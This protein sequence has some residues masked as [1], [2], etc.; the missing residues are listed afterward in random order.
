MITAEPKQR[1]YD[2]KCNTW[3]GI[4]RMR[5]TDAKKRARLKKL[6]FDIDP[7]YVIK[8]FIETNYLCPYLGVKFEK[9]N[10][11]F[12]LSIDRIDSKQGY[13]KGNIEITSRLANTMKNKA[14]NEQLIVFAKNIL[15][16]KDT[17]KEIEKKNTLSSYLTTKQ[18]SEQYPEYSYNSLVHFRN[19]NR[20]HF[21]YVKLG[22]K[23]L[24]KREDIEYLLFI[25]S[26]K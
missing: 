18:V 14:T 1:E 24:Y 9:R 4:I 22:S 10:S 20:S 5:V 6:D 19:T 17:S 12:V 7:K 26:G 21:P 16:V 13:I 23:I 2:R 8:K 25:R 3:N 11:D 15:K